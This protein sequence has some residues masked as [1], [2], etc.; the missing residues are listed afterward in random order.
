MADRLCE[1]DFV[2]VA[3]VRLAI[4]VDQNRFVCAGHG[5]PALRGTN[6]YARNRIR[7]IPIIPIRVTSIR[8][9]PIRVA[10]IRVAAIRDG[11]VRDTAIW[12]AAIQVSA[13][14]N[15]LHNTEHRI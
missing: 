5:V 4:A 14:S 8:V 11:H 6:W 2:P 13:K 10:A 3:A 1:L 15:F 9:T 12:A 7:V